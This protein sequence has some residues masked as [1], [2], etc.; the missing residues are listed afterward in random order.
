VETVPCKSKLSIFQ[1]VIKIPFILLLG[2]IV[3][4]S[5]LYAGVAM[6]L[7]GDD[8]CEMRNGK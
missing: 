1:R 8:P 7:F 4:L 2:I 5:W 6:L 3:N